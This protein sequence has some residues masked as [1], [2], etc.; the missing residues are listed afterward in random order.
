MN[1]ITTLP[2]QTTSR[3]PVYRYQG[4]MILAAAVT[5]SLMA[6]VGIFSARVSS[7]ALATEKDA[8]ERNYAALEEFLDQFDPP[9]GGD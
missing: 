3:R 7:G 5:L 2:P 1:P 9:T 4:L 8:I 6:V